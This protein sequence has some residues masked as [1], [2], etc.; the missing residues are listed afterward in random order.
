MTGA[1]LQAVADTRIGDRLSVLRRP[2]PGRRSDLGGHGLDEDL[3][4]VG[5]PQARGRTG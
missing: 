4:S 2:V 3:S 1:Q 5:Q